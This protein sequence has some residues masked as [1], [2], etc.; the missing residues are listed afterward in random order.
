MQSASAARSRSAAAVP[1]TLIG[2]S[3]AGERTG[4]G[5][6]D[7]EDRPSLAPGGAGFPTYNTAIRELVVADPTLSSIASD[8]AGNDG[9]YHWSYAGYRNVVVPAL[10]AKTKL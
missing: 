9:A 3:V 6:Y 8:G 10:V 2:R 5:A 7:E 4:A 1:T